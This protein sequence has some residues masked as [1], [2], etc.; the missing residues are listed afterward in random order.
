MIYLM[1]VIVIIM[2]LTI[3]AY[4]E[5]VINGTSVV[6]AFKN[7][8]NRRYLN[9]KFDE[10]LNEYSDLFRK[11]GMSY[12]IKESLSYTDSENQVE[13]D[14]FME[15]KQLHI[16]YALNYDTIHTNTTYF[17]DLKKESQGGFYIVNSCENFKNA[18]R[19]DNEYERVVNDLFNQYPQISSKKY[20]IM[21]IIKKSL[22]KENN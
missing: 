22:L 4:S 16:N 20:E 14:I 7:K 17:K 13:L 2:A 6:D 19:I 15:D 9:F 5:I 10:N 1:I 3:D 12:T 21:K 11:K 8:W 18:I